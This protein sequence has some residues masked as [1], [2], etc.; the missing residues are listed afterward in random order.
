MSSVVCLWPLLI[1]PRSSLIAVFYAL[2]PISRMAT[3]AKW[4][5]V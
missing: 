5:K 3:S 1:V 2:L 4:S